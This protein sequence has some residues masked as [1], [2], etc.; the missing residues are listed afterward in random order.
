MKTRG[1][2]IQKDLN[3]LLYNRNF[4]NGEDNYKIVKGRGDFLCRKR[5]YPL[6]PGCKRTSH[7]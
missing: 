3:V 5:K 1:G 7:V 4:Q 6:A 2:N